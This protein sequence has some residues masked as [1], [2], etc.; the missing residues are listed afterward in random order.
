LVIDADGWCSVSSLLRLPA[1][2]TY[3]ESDISVVVLESHSKTH[4]RFQVQRSEDGFCVRAT[5]KHSI[6]SDAASG[7]PQGDAQ[8]LATDSSMVEASLQPL[9]PPELSQHEPPGLLEQPKGPENVSLEYASQTEQAAPRPLQFS[10]FPQHELPPLLQPLDAPK[11]ASLQDA[12]LKELAITRPQLQRPRRVRAHSRS[13]SQA[14][15]RDPWPNGVDPFRKR[16]ANASE[17]ASSAGVRSTSES[18]CDDEEG[19]SASSKGRLWRQYSLPQ[20]ERGKWWTCVAGSA[21]ADASSTT[22]SA[23]ADCFRE[24]FHGS[25]T[26][27]CHPDNGC[28][29]WVHELTQEWFY[30]SGA[31]V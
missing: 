14:P 15:P 26:Q 18:R 2:S 3:T 12:T 19:G 29:Y 6:L 21:Q 31:R 7:N 8:P 28:P 11:P 25:W 30:A 13:G 5:H 16:T 22:E 24:D 4:P 9:L 27:Y 23:D 1:L 20:P 17:K 10:E